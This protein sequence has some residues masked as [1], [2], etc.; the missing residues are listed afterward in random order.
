MKLNCNWYISVI[1][2][3]CR[4]SVSEENVFCAAFSVLSLRARSLVL[5]CSSYVALEKSII[6]PLNAVVINVLV[7]AGQDSH[8]NC[9]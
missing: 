6:L 1:L 2:V 5:C 3:S 4:V 8:L 9:L 7:T